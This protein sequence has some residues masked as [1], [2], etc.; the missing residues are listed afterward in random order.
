MTQQEKAFTTKLN[1][2]SFIFRTQFME[3]EDGLPHTHHGMHVP[4]HTPHTTLLIN[5]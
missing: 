2:Q 4:A 3:R 1:N 5:Y